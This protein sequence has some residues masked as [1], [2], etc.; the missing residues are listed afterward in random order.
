MKILKMIAFEKQGEE[1]FLT[2]GARQII[3]DCPGNV[4]SYDLRGEDGHSAHV[5]IFHPTNL[6]Q[7]Q[8]PVAIINLDA[9]IW[10]EP[11]VNRL[12]DERGNKRGEK[13]TY[14]P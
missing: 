12:F 2:A 7:C 4:M 10:A 6:S 5:D 14:Q 9:P 13:W 3:P 8:E 11:A 1:T